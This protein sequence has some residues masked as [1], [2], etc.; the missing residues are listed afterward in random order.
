MEGTPVYDSAGTRVGIIRHLVIEKA[1]GHVAYVVIS[2]GGV[3]GIGS[4]T[5]PVPWEWLTYDVALRGYRTGVTEA[6]VGAAPT[7]SE[8]L[9]CDQRRESAIRDR[10]D[11]PP[12]R[13]V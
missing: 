1:S 4:L 9:W 11:L 2:F 5:L 3:L 6:E 10:W 7:H 13:G 8:K 12:F